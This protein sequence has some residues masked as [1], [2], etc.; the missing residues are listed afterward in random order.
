MNLSECIKETLFLFVCF[1]PFWC[2]LVDANDNEVDGVLGVSR[3]NGS[4]AQQQ[5]PFCFTGDVCWLKL[6]S[7]TRT[8][9]MGPN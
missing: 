8:R 1:Q 7:L 9:K 6:G 3:E 2:V 4:G 5:Q